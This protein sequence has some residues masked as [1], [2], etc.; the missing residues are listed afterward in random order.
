[1]RRFRTVAADGSIVMQ[2]ASTLHVSPG[3]FE[4]MRIPVV[5]GELFRN[6]RDVTV[7]S[8]SFAKRAWPGERGL[9][10]MI[11]SGDDLELTV[12]GV[13]GE[14]LNSLTDPDLPD[15]YVPMIR[16]PWSSVEVIARAGDSGSVAVAALRKAV[17]E[18]DADLPLGRG[19]SM[20]ETIGRQTGR[21]DFLAVLLLLFGATAVALVVVALY[22]VVA[23][24]VSQRSREIA[25]RIAVGGTPGR[26]AALF[27]GW[28]VWRVGLGVA[29]GLVSAIS[30]SR[31][32]AGQ[33]HG[34]TPTEPWVYT[35]LC[36]LL[37]GVALAAV[38]LPA[39]RAGR[40]DAMVILRGE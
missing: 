1:V 17:I 19:E 16:S 26:I 12:V 28:G 40:I 23:Y 20:S 5:A 35:A 33:L 36:V 14:V 38:W 3:F 31:I 29:L 32:L 22:G 11:R 6:E 9:G 25:V 10:K 27:L 34:V 15:V 4:V 7:V 8:D 37:I 30:L 39:R 21:S 13:V 2:D 18:L 24:A